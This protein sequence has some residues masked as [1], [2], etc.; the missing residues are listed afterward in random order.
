MKKTIILI[1]L[2]SCTFFSRAQSGQAEILSEKIAQKMFD[3]LSLTGDQKKRIYHTNMFLY[4][5][6]TNAWKQFENQ[7][8]IL[9]VHIQ[10]IENSRDSLYKRIIA[11]ENKYNLY[12]Q[13]KRFLVSN[14]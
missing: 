3:S 7:D 13:K 2:I 8:S 6:K 12:R 11:D 10:R 4:H 5:Q 14:N 1:L 9:R